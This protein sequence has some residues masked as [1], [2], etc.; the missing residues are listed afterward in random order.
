MLASPRELIAH[1]QFDED[2]REMLLTVYDDITR[3][4]VLNNNEYAVVLAERILAIAEAGEHEPATI[5]AQAAA[6]LPRRE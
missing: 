3:N 5:E 1:S 2:V 4:Y 6:G